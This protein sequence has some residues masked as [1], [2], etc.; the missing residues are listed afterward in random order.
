[1]APATG[2]E[3]PSTAIA[4]LGRLDDTQRRRFGRG[5]PALLLVIVGGLTLVLTALAVRLHIG[6]PEEESTQIADI[7][8][9]AVGSGRLYGAFQPTSSLLLLAA[10]GSAFQ[11][12]PGLL[13]TLAGTPSAP[14]CCRPS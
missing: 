10:A 2:V 5:T 6:I 8:H 11:A 14:V 12:G 1:M 7:A 4:Q 13:K 3:A 9:A